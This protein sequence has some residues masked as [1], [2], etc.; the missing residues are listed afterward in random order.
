MY[1]K[2]LEE[3]FSLKPLNLTEFG[4]APAHF[5][6]VGHEA[7]T[8]LV[9]SNDFNVV[10]NKRNNKAVGCF[11]NDFKIT[12]PQDGIN[13]VESML[14]ESDLDL[15][16]IK[17][18]ME[19]GSNEALL[20]VT[21][22]LPSQTISVG[23]PELNDIC[24]LQIKHKTSFNGTWA[25]Q[26]GFNTLRLK[27]LNGMVG[28]ENVSLFKKKNTK[29]LD[30]E[31]GKK[32]LITMVDAFK[33]QEDTWN[34]WLNEEVSDRTALAIFANAAGCKAPS[35][36]EDP[37]IDPSSV[38]NRS[39]KSSYPYQRM[40]SAYLDLEKKRLGSNLWAVFNVLTDWSTHAPV[41]P[42][43]QNNVIS[44]TD[45]REKKVAQAIRGSAFLKLNQLLEAG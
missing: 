15:T 5:E 1:D 45:R 9:Q 22:T 11:K 35:E 36:M 27:C 8:Q 31:S 25:W 4:I 34:G 19:T 13:A 33:R 30:P 40:K 26:I 24:A 2:K 7:R 20:Q 21:W 14:L 43:H 17:R 29:S 6:T 38:M 39:L 18:K 32:H 28:V 44:I 16:G 23:D 37:N 42:K 12:P 41:L 10:Y 3:R